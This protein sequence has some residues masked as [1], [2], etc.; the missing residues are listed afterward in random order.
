MPVFGD[1]VIP[2]APTRL[3]EDPAVVSAVLA[4]IPAVVAAIVAAVVTVLDD[5]GGPDDRRGPRRPVRRS[6]P[7]DP[8]VLCPVACQAPSVSVRR[9]ASMAASSAC[10]GIRP[11]AMSWPPA[12]RIDEANG[13]AQLF[14]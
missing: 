10:V 14:S 4:P 11:L 9:S 13:P 12:R 3:P 6:R 5:G 7:V 2:D 1:T 8:L